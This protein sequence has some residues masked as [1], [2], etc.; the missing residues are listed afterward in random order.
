MV[1]REKTLICQFSETLEFRQNVASKF[2]DYFEKCL[3][4]EKSA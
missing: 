2:G 1:G 4:D 3:I